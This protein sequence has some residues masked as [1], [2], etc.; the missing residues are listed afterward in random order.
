MPP[1]VETV[2]VAGETN[3]SENSSSKPTV[4]IIYP[5]PEVRNIVDKTASFVARNGLEF[6]ARIRKNELNNPK[7]N[8]LNT[9]DP[10]HAYYQ[11]KVKDIR[12]GKLAE[13]LPVA[14]PATPAPTPAGKPPPSAPTSAP[15]SLAQ[16][17][18]Q[19]EILKQFQQ[20][21]PV[22]PKEPPPEFEF[23]VDPPSISAME[24][25]IVK[26]TA[27]FV[28]RNGR[29]FLTSLMN[30]EARNYQFDFLRPQHSLFQYFTRLLE[31][32]TKVLIPPKD[33][34]ARLNEG[35][36]NPNIVLQEVKRRAD[37]Q[38]HQEA[39]KRREEE[40]AE[41]ER[42]SYAQ[43]DWH[44]FVVV[45]SVDYQ[46]FEIGNFPPPTTPEEV[47]ARILLQERYEEGQD[48]EMQLES[49]EE[50]EDEEDSDG[51]QA[52]PPPPPGAPPSLSFKGDGQQPPP[53][54]P[55]AENVIV[56][57]DYNPKAVAKPQ[58]RPP[59]PDEY[60]ISPITGERIPASQ[61]AEHMRIG[62]LDPRWLE[63]RDRQMQEKMTQESVYAPGSAIENSLRALAERRTDIFGVGDEETAIGKKIG[64]EER[65]KDEAKWEGQSPAPPPAAGEGGS[66]FQSRPGPPAGLVTIQEQIAQIHKNKALMSGISEEEDGLGSNGV[67]AAAPPKPPQ[68]LMSI[69][70]RPPVM[71]S[72]P[73]PPP[74]MMMSIPQ[75]PMPMPMVPQ[76]SFLPMPQSMG[77]MQGQG[78]RD[79]ME[80]E[81]P[82][83]RQRNEDQLMPEEA[84]LVRYPGLLHF[85]IGAPVYAEKPEW[86]LQ[87]QQLSFSLLP[88]EQI[89]VVKQK[90]S[91]A[92]GMPPA[93]QKLFW[94]GLY[95]KDN[96]SLAFYNVTPDAVVQL[97]VKERG[98]RK[99]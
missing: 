3:L 87:G 31:Q 40:E 91:E 9:G 38:R 45:E 71:M 52:K 63:Q 88:T 65:R 76:N 70:P 21:A 41:R 72:A 66:T 30:R 79:V 14:T 25:D 53:V 43:I 20:E 15:A 81:P 5:P 4:G 99:K 95:F 22:I 62:L 39:Q 42:V 85:H 13:A 49:E 77:M 93:K 94:E 86:K 48:V 7:F 55:S 2:P 78:G 35:C 36:T 57:K 84:F 18:K 10:Y 28:A 26:L 83:K 90:I 11:Y 68:Q 59:A 51:E 58:A 89:A 60:L 46:P 27:Q 23:I 69:P 6:E 1:A 97:Q 17:Q 75:P 33:L 24:L 50:D 74:M 29:Q 82:S 92:T 96:H 80:E 56:R 67:V 37:W 47:G 16:Q 19:Q 54:A 61:V 73:Q 64:E 12:E 34:M 32:Y 8:F 98:G 44:D